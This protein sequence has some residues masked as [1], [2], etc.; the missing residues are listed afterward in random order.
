MCDLA[1]NQ[2]TSLPSFLSIGI[3]LPRLQQGI[4]ATFLMK[5][6]RRVGQVLVK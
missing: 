6:R 5:G 2:G 1:H 3:T 4:F